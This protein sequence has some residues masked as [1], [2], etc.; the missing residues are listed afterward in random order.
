MGLS[1]HCSGP[2]QRFSSAAASDVMEFWIDNRM[3]M[4]PAQMVH[5]GPPAALE[6]GVL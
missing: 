1:V 4:M 5:E 2:R 3:G 6:P